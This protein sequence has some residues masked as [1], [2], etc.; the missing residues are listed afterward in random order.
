MLSK[1]PERTRDAVLLDMDPED[2]PMTEE[3]ADAFD[4]SFLRGEIKISYGSGSGAYE[5]T[6]A[7]VNMELARQGSS[8]KTLKVE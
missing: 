8:Q 7:W 5:E 6:E 2:Y 4:E 3:E 1:K